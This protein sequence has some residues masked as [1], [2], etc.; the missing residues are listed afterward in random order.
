LVSRKHTSL[1]LIVALALV[2][3][4]GFLVATH[5]YKPLLDQAQYDV[6]AQSIAAGHG[7]PTTV[8]GSTATYPPLYPVL[9]AT[10]NAVTGDGWTVG[11]LMSCL[12]GA[13]VV[14]LIGLVVREVW[15]QRSAL[16]AAG[17]AAIYPPFVLL[18]ATLLS[19][20]LFLPLVLA[21][22]LAVLRH[23]RSASGVK[24]AALAGAACGLAVLTR[25]NGVWLLPATLI[26][27]WI[28]PSKLRLG[29]RAAVASAV[30]IIAAASVLTP[31][32]IRNEI[33]FGEFVITDT[34]GGATI[35]AAY[36]ST[37]EA[38]HLARTSFPGTRQYFVADTALGKTRNEAMLD[39]RLRNAALRFA[40]DHPKL[41]A[42]VTFWNLVRSLRL[43]GGVEG[44]DVFVSQGMTQ[45]SFGFRASGLVGDWSQFA[46]WLLVLLAGAGALLLIFRP[47]MGKR[48]P[49]FLWAV[50]VLLLSILVVLG[51][52]RMR[53][54]IDPFLIL[55]ASAAVVAI[56][57]AVRARATA[58]AAH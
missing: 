26:G 58:I 28:G 56:S 29:H 48:G 51:N 44:M 21:T 37:V 55:L 22:C 10:A 41:V 38:D 46:T 27:L 15:G 47:P 8:H 24:W 35:A 33:V 9:L 4:L 40:R 16:V 3:R 18:S 6:Y 39:H 17:L 42:R 43:G 54:P 31:W 5:E 32:V 11:R 57:D 30:S 52:D 14:L 45:D 53:L 25:G 7:Y 12:L 20:T 19:E 2:V 34:H 36:N 49:L 13:V 1:G 50:P 23:R